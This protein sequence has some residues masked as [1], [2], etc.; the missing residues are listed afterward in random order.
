MEPRFKPRH[1]G[2]RIYTLTVVLYHFYLYHGILLMVKA[3]L[4]LLRPEKR[5]MGGEVTKALGYKV[6]ARGLGQWG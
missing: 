2:S 4:H 3:V 5:I 1:A 6:K